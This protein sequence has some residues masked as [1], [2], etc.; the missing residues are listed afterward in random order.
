MAEGLNPTQEQW[1]VQ[2][3]NQLGKVT[4]Y[5]DWQHS[6]LGPH[7]G[8]NILEMG[9]GIGLITQFLLRKEDALISA[10]D[11]S[12]VSLSQLLQQLAPPS[13]LRLIRGDLEDPDLWLRLSAPF[14]TVIAVSLL[15]H[16]ED[17]ALLLQRLAPCLASGGQVLLIVPAHPWLYGSID[18]L[19]CHRRRYDKK[20]IAALFRQSGL[21]PLELTY[22][23]LP[24]ALAWWYR[25][26]VRKQ[27]DFS[28]QEL[29]WFNRLIPVIRRLESW[30]PMPCG[31]SQFA[32]ARKP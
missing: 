14:D 10:V 3:L 15:E 26:V 22:F 17:D 11:Y 9:C 19:A 4:H 5:L 20:R 18:V 8:K 23:N 7:L 25:F 1:Q 2:I 28:A 31:L 6:L 16:L 21:E 32:R 12:P 13:R 30:L 27:S 29:G 24:G